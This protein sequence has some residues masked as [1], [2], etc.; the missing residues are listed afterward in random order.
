VKPISKKLLICLN[1]FDSGGAETQVRRVTVGLAERGWNITIVSL[2]DDM[3]ETPELTDGNIQKV[4]LNG[5]RGFQAA[6]SFPA[7]LS[8]IKN[9]KPDIILGL[10]IPADPLVRVAGRL[11]NIPVVSS[12]RNQN[13]GGKTVN[14]MLRITDYL[15]T[16]VTANAEI[17]KKELGSLISS[18]PGRIKITPN[19]LAPSIN[20][21]LGD[22]DIREDLAIPE[23]A[24]F[25][26]AVGSQR[27]QKN[28][29]GLLK[30]FSKIDSGYLAIAGTN[31]QKQELTQLA[32]RL[33]IEDR[34][35]ILGRRSDIPH[36]LKAADALVLASHHEG[37]PN[38]VLEAMQLGLPV[39]ATSVGDIPNIIEDGKNGWVI[40]PGNEKSLAK[41]MDSVMAMNKEQLTSIGLI[42]KKR[43]LFLHNR[44]KILDKWECILEKAV[45]K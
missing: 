27:P 29:V 7:L 34:V 15:A 3:I 20:N 12:I 23:D 40:E 32:K 5:K 10:M 42:G 11:F 4:N 28:Y 37:T 17:T 26:L 35:R 24:F 39:V 2:L 18:N 6:F 8:V 45:G 14:R 38:S 1:R 33:N 44:E 16:T 43:I 21:H 30:A 9:V 31:Y 22:I 25:W 36:L 19:L 41:K 13:V